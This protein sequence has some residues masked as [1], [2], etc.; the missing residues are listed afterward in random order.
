MKLQSNVKIKKF[1]WTIIPLLST[2][3]AHAIY[4]NIYLPKQ[5]YE[6]LLSDDPKQKN[7][8][9]LIHEQTH[10]KRQKEMGWFL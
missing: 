9:V 8:S 1:P 2:H 3:T 4:P 10:I 6:D 5:V 7:V